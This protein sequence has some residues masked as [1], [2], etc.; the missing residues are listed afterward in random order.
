MDEEKK[1]AILGPDG[2]PIVTDTAKI[3]GKSRE[4]IL[5]EMAGDKKAEDY[6]VTTP[7]MPKRQPC[8]IHGG[9]CKRVKRTAGGAKYYCPSCR[10]EFL[11]RSAKGM[12]YERA[13]EGGT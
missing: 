11:I 3:A 13:T 2:Q 6:F 1:I 10:G 9:N 4:Q 8:P 5:K 12:T 7:N